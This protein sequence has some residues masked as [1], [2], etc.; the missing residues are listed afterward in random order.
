M[1]TTGETKA[2]KGGKLGERDRE[3]L[4]EAASGRIAYAHCQAGLG[5]TG[6][7]MAV[8]LREAGLGG[9]EALDE[10]VRLRA[11]AGLHAGSP[12]FEEQREFV[13]RWP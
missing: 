3:L 1:T 5:R 2:E 11:A 4:T 13:R 12:E 10:L 6:T 9:Q 7:V 8:L